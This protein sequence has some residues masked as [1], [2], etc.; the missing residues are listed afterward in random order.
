MVLVILLLTDNLA[1]FIIIIVT[2]PTPIFVGKSIDLKLK[3]EDGFEIIYCKLK[4]LKLY[5]NKP[6][7]FLFFF[8]FVLQLL[9][10]Q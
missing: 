3:K 10:L 8:L 5:S 6:E 9:K 2:S 1:S 4:L 7:R